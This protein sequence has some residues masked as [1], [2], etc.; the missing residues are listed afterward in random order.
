VTRHCHLGVKKV[1]A[2]LLLL[3]AT[4]LWAE[5]PPQ[6]SSAAGGCFFCSR[7]KRHPAKLSGRLEEP[8]SDAMSWFRS[9]R[10]AHRLDDAIKRLEIARQLAPGNTSVYPHL[11][12]A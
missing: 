1:L 2:L 12:A 9:C 5:A 4:S 11:A 10:D 7:R 3:P 6:S 8:A